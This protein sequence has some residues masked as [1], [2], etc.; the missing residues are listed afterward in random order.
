M[1]VV[2]LMAAIV[3]G[4]G[5]AY[6]ALPDFH[7][8]VDIRIDDLVTMVRRQ[9]SPGFVAVRPTST[10]ASSELSGHPGQFAADLVS[11]DYW[12]ADTA[13]DP[14][15]ALVFTF[16]GRTDLDNLLVTSGAATDYARLARPRTIQLTYSDGTGEELTLRD[17]RTPASYPIHARQVTSVTLRITGVYPGSGSTAVAMAEVEFYHLR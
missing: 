16:A 3:I 7:R 10:R 17:D 13:R 9:L 11:N 6:A 4:G 2:T 1:F 15:P 8:A 14:Q 12:A 5:L